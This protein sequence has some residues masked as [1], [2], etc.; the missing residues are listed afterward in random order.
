MVDRAVRWGQSNQ[1]F[2]NL[3]TGAAVTQALNM[4]W[5]PIIQQL[6][7][8]TTGITIP[9]NQFAIGTIGSVLGTAIGGIGIISRN[10]SGSPLLALQG[11]G[12]HGVV[13][14]E[15]WVRPAPPSNPTLFDDWPTW[16]LT[17]A[18]LNV[19]DYVAG[20]TTPQ[21]ADLK[22]I[23]VLL[24][25]FDVTGYPLQRSWIEDD[26]R[27]WAYGCMRMATEIRTQAGKTAA[28]MPL[29]IM[30]PIPYSSGNNQA[31]EIV[32]QAMMIVARDA[33][34][35]A[36]VVIGN[37]MDVVL[38]RN[39]GVG[40]DDGAYRFHLNG[41]DQVY[42]ARKLA[43]AEAR[44]PMARQ[45]NPNALNHAGHGPEIVWARWIDSTTLDVFVCHDG[46]ANLTL[47]A[48]A[49]RGWRV[50]YAGREVAVSGATVPDGRR[51]RLTL[52]TACPV[53]EMARVN[54]GWGSSRLIEG[55][56]GS[57]GT[58]GIYDDASTWDAKAIPAA[59]T[60]ADRVNM[61]L[62]KTPYGGL[63][64]ATGAPPTDILLPL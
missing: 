60:G 57:H 28:Q 15:H 42:L 50:E 23:G 30:A 3:D 12:Y 49:T 6:L 39:D 46:G 61:I 47:P 10:S 58:G 53:P 9:G 40:G 48:T 45:W 7:D 8:P 41:A 11:D 56:T 32:H 43:Y 4:I 37:C 44:T 17:N 64:A 25:E 54:Y 14:G 2:I 19:R 33:R 51:V 52:A 55:G 20:L 5:Q 24:N 31:Y 1:V 18:G 59:L 22:G 26:P 35:H 21:K 62:R 63:R 13:G 16:P 36:R 38:D 27:V 29:S 34:M